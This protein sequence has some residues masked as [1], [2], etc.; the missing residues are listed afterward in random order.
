MEAQLQ[1]V[2]DRAGLLLMSPQ[3]WA[4]M[5]ASFLALVTG[6]AERVV[7]FIED[8]HASRTSGSGTH[9]PQSTSEP[10]LE[11]VRL[12][13]L[14]SLAMRWRRFRALDGGRARHAG[15]RRTRCAEQPHR[16]GSGDPVGDG[17]TDR[18]LVAASR[19]QN[20]HGFSAGVIPLDVTRTGP[21]LHAP[22]HRGFDG[23]PAVQYDGMHH[24]VVDAGRRATDLCAGRGSTIRIPRTWAGPRGAPP[25]AC[26]GRIGSMSIPVSDARDGWAPH[27]ASADAEWR[28]VGAA[29]R[30]PSTRLE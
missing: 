4:A 24:D 20:G 23:R 11:P 3:L 7:V 8:H 17:G 26:F 28:T 9:R 5:A 18:D 12:P 27:R 10:S 13:R 25:H 2:T 1:S 19:V 14:P 16:L 30:R 21:D 15:L 22:L 6:L 29:T